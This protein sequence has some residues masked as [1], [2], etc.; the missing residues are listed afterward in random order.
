MLSSINFEGLKACQGTDDAS[1]NGCR[2]NA[3]LCHPLL[4]NNPH[5][6]TIPPCSAFRSYVKPRGRR[7][8]PR[9][10][11]EGLTILFSQDVD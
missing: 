5:S 9:P 6:F 3:L 8:V 10:L 4:E 2:Q 11:V 1:V 7:I